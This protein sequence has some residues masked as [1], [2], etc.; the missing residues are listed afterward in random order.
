LANPTK[1]PI[2][3]GQW[4]YCEMETITCTEPK[5]ILGQEPV[6]FPGMLSETTSA[7]QLDSILVGEGKTNRRENRTEQERAAKLSIFFKVPDH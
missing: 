3:E 5:N 7:I 1:K 6:F 4:H 2:L